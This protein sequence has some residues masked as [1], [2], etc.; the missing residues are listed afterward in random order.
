M[1]EHNVDLFRARRL[2]EVTAGVV[3]ASAT[4][5][6][7]GWWTK[8]SPGVP[9]RRA[10]S[11]LPPQHGLER[12][13]FDRAS[14]RSVEDWYQSHGVVPRIVV[15]TSDPDWEALDAFLASRGYSVDAPTEMLTARS[16]DVKDRSSALSTRLRSEPQID[17]ISVT[18]TPGLNAEVL[19]DLSRVHSTNAA[20]RDRTVALGS[21]LQGSGSSTFV[22]AV[23]VGPEPIG[24]AFGVHERDLVGV[25]G[26]AVAV[27]WRR[28][29]VAGSLAGALATGA[30]LVGVSEMYLQVEAD[31]DA[32]RRLYRG[33][34]FTLSHRYHYRVKKAS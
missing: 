24:L 19:A 17:E 4:A 8:A 23:A 32:A 13:G 31:N 11:A 34:G 18:V 5:M 7:E 10:N 21:A 16:A 20:A 9:L 6:I 33:L 30:E 22:G 28:R 1:A 3:S 12:H 25:F 2:D 14:L 29:G 15:S 27:H 26:M